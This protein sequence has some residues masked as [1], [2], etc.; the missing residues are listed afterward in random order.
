MPDQFTKLAYATIAIALMA[1]AM[2][3]SANV[4]EAAGTEGAGLYSGPAFETAV[5]HLVNQYCDVVK[6]PKGNPNHNLDLTCH[7]PD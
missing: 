2:R 4:A 5:I 3:P 1:L 6:R 7:F